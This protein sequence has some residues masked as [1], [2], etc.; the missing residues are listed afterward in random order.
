MSKKSSRFQEGLKSAKKIV[1]HPN[2]K[3][4]MEPQKAIMTLQSAEKAQH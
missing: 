4:S 3:R 1:D 2:E